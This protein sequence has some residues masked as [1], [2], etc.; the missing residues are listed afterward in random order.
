[1]WLF[2]Q[3]GDE[4]VARLLTEGW[5]DA[6][7]AGILAGADHRGDHPGPQAA[8]RPAAAGAGCR[9]GV[10]AGHASNPGAW[11]R[12]W[13][14]LSLDGTTLDVADIPDNT[15]AFG[16][17]PASRGGSAFAR[18]RVLAGRVRHHAILDAAL[19]PMPSASSAWQRRRRV[20]LGQVGRPGPSRLRPVAHHGPDRRGPAV[21]HPRQRGPAGGPDPGGWLLPQPDRRGPR[22]PPRSRPDRRAGGGVSPPG[23]GRPR[24][25]APTGW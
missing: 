11:Y 8:W 1:M 2:S 18:L 24:R 19:G 7:L 9:G 14:L 10:A 20:H 6:P 12:G 13:R 25:Q 5:L 23:P 3:V 15:A 17:P 4:E 21:A 22:P 16:R